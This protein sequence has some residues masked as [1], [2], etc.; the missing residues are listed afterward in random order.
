MTI[1][2]TSGRPQLR[3]RRQVDLKMRTTDLEEFTVLDEQ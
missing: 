2:Y 3:E 1:P